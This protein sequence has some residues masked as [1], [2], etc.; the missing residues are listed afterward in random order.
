MTP[1][2]S[3]RIV[4]LGCLCILAVLACR[5]PVDAQLRLVDEYISFTQLAKLALRHMPAEE[6]WRQAAPDTVEI[7]I[8]RKRGEEDQPALWYHSG[9]SKKKPLLL[10]LHSWSDNYRQHFGIPYAVFAA[11]NDWIFIHPDYRGEFNNAVATASEQA[12]Q[13]VLDALEYAKAHAPVDDKR[14]YLAGF[15][16][17]AMMSLIMVGRY[18]EKFTA[19]LVWVPVFDLNDW[20]A[21]LTHS[22][23]YYRHDYMDDIRASCGGNPSAD[24]QARAECRKRSPS[25]YLGNA[26]GKGVKVFISGGIDDP[27]VPVSHAIRAFNELADQHDGISEADYRFIDDSEKLP[28]SLRGQRK[29]N[30]LFEEA[31]LPVLFERTSLGATLILFDGG[32]DIAY[33]AGFFWLSKQS[34]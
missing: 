3:L 33:N 18:P 12:V 26:R 15:S 9:T 5:K 27:F 11:K 1:S 34:R 14:I 2:K 4:F 8:P 23:L 25:A 32:H 17:G 21:A 19:A 20:Y 7:S 29:K 28:A 13:D 22:E 30:L 24:D 16:G 31:G 6:A 10:V